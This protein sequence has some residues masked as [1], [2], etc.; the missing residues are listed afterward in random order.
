[1]KI[2]EIHHIGVLGAGLM[3]HGIAQVF[4]S[5]GYKVNIFDADA[6][7]LGK[8][9]DKIAANFNA[10]ISL[11]LASPADRERCLEL[12]TRA[13]KGWSVAGLLPLS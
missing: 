3:G 12:V 5:A 10:F 9:K 2:E 1:M 11:K 8:A 4:A 13:S 6:A 7:V